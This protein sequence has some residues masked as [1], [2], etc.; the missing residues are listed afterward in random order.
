MLFKTGARVFDDTNYIY[1]LKWDGFRCIAHKKKHIVTLISRNGWCMNK[2]FPEIV[3]E[4]G[5]VPQ[6]FV[7]DGELIIM[8]QDVADFAALQWRGRL[9]KEDKIA[10]AAKALPATYVVFDLLYLN[11][12]FL[13]DLTLMERKYRLSSDIP[14][15]ERVIVNDWV[16]GKGQ[17]LFATSKLIGHEGIVAKLKNSLYYPGKRV[18]T[19]L[20]IKHWLEESVTI[21]GYKT[22]PDFGLLVTTEGKKISTIRLGIKPEE[23]QAFLAVVSELIIGEKKG[24]VSIQPLMKCVVK[25]KEWTEDGRMRHPT[26]VRFLTET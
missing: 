3:T 22:Q 17:E 16:E 25:F 11:G 18:D 4:L 10:T 1:E 23:Q 19:W 9:R 12:K 8:G 6:D 26:F 7:L 21:V 5:R 20:K 2:N 24:L 14:A 15:L 13:T